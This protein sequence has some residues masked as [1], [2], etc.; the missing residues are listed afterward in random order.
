MKRLSVV[1]AVVATTAIIAAAVFASL[2]FG[3][4]RAS[5]DVA[6][7][8]TD[9]TSASVGWTAVPTEK[10]MFGRIKSL[11]LKG[12]HYEMRFDPALV[13]GGV[14]ANV[15]QAEDNGQTCKPVLNDGYVIDDN[16]RLF[17]YLVPENAEITV[18]GDVDITSSTLITA[19]ELA[20]KIGADNAESRDLDAH[21]F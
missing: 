14:T 20:Q 5:S 10:W 16:H 12:D 7:V 19:A 8:T 6:T 9:S 11:V 3:N 1:L 2:A 21:G 17:T 4:D 15:A 18:L 13:L